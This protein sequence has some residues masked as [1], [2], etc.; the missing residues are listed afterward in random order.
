[1]LHVTATQVSINQLDSLVRHP[2]LKLLCNSA[3]FLKQQLPARL[4]NHI[5][6][7]QV[8]P[9]RLCG[10]M[11]SGAGS[12]RH[13]LAHAQQACARCAACLPAA[14]V[15]A[16]LLQALPPPEHPQ[17]KELLASTISSKAS[18]LDVAKD[19]RLVGTG[20][21]AV[22]RGQAPIACLAAAC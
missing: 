19:W 17:L 16:V 11:Q 14:C 13:A 15:C 22:A 7:L 12:C 6:R 8:G 18:G 3:T 5:H 9:L 4:S 21:E 20:A 1:M 10:A 2:S